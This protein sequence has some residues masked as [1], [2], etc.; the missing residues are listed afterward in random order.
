MYSSID[1]RFQECP[2]Q[3]WQQQLPRTNPPPMIKETPK[4]A[5]RD[6]ETRLPM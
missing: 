2:F 4:A 3:R 5:T 6:P 1:I